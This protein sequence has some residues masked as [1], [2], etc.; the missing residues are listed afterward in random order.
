MLGNF[1][2]PDT[3]YKGLLVFHGTGTGKTCAVL[4]VAEKFK[5]QVKRYKLKIYILVPGPLLKEAWR[6]LI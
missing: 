5:Q 2:N 4:A 1:I 6:T 3:P